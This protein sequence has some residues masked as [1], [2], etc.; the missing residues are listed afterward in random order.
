MQNKE[1]IPNLIQAEI[2]SHPKSVFP[3]FALYEYKLK[4]G[5]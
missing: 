3:N 5:N 2:K 1:Q 4:K